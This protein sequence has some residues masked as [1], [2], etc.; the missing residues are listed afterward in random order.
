MHL[1]ILLS[2]GPIELDFGILISF[3]LGISFGFVLLFL[4][5]I[6]AVLT[7]LNKNSRLKKVDEA[8]IDEEEIKWLIEDAQNQF[9][10]KELR[11]EK[12]MYNYLFEIIQELSID[13]SKKFYPYSKYPYLELT[14][15][16]TL[17]LSHYI[18]DR[19][20]QLLQGRILA[21]TRGFTLAKIKEMTDIKTKVDDSLVGKAAKSYSKI[22]KVAFA[23]LNA[24]N[25][26]YWIRKFTKE[27]M[28]NVVVLRIGLSLI[29]ITGEE[30][31]K[32]YSKKVF[33]LEKELETGIGDLYEMIKEDVQKEGESL[34]EK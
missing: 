29:S 19:L 15:D 27:T 25:P 18:T 4:L 30:T 2:I 6:Y 1:N 24:V 20:D 12:G 23:T 34:E 3:L 5:Y 28:L 21:L 9:K 17:K 7:G 16:E 26:V 11:N 32:I 10:N 31:Y 22:S 33:N 8:D 13:I 14:I